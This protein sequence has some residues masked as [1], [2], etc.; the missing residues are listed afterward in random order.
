MSETISQA[1]FDRERA[2]RKEAEHLLEEKSRE[3]YLANTGL[4]DALAKLKSTQAQLVQSEKMASVGQMAAGVAH[5]I[6]NPIGFV[7]SNLDSLRQYVEALTRVIRQDNKL[8]EESRGVASLSGL[9][10]ASEEAR[11]QAELA[12]IMDDLDGLID[13]SIEGARRIRNIVAD[14][15]DFSHVDNPDMVVIDIHTLI[16]KTINVATNEIKYKAEVVCEYGEVPPVTCYGG[17]I[18]QALLNLLVNA[19]HAIEE[20]GTITIRTGS[21]Q[22]NAWFEVS[23]TGRGI[24]ADVL[25]KIYDPFFT[26]KKVGE[27]TGLGLHLVHKIVAGH[28]GSIDVRSTEGRGTTFRITLPIHC[29]PEPQTQTVAGVSR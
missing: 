18:S 14:L 13:E 17:K 16:D 5:E 19:A 11:E 8:L 3:L 25:S 2:A 1:K 26:T 28:N 27:G 9:V 6:N 4:S 10:I 20:Y 12:Y 22:D 24:P 23:D 21:D 7:S 29:N 15:K